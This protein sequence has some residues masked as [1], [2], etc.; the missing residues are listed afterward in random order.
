MPI[1]QRVDRERRR[2]V[3]EVWG[4]ITVKDIL[5][6][7]DLAIADPDFEPGFDFLS[8]HRRVERPLTT[9]QAK[10]TAAH[11]ESHRADMAHARWAVV[12]GNPASYGMIRMLAVY[13]EKVPVTVRAFKRME[14]AEAWLA[15]KAIAG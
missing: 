3:V 5:R 10:R 15:E 12:T 6:A 1:T 11:L 4:R 9:R 14:E 2:V 8:D 13:A 7:I